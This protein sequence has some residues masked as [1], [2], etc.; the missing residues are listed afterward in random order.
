MNFV[1]EMIIMNN[2]PKLC[3]KLKQLFAS[4][5]AEGNIQRRI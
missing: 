2:T 4:N 3:Y 1:S 5:A